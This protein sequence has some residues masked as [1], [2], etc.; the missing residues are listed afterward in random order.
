M[1]VASIH[2]HSLPLAWPVLWPMLEKAARRTP[3]LSE[4]DVR[5]LVENGHAQLWAI[6][7][8][9]APVAAITTQVTLE[10]ETRCR[11]W[12]VGGAR[13]IEWLPAFLGT[14]EPWARSLG[15]KAIWGTQS[16]RAWVRISRLLGCEPIEPFE[17]TPSWG[18]RL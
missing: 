2:L 18:R 13:M 14:V 6:V 1:T 8:N 10:P 3:D 17:G 4:M 9:G 16:R 7:E 11:V 15:C 5:R 12:L